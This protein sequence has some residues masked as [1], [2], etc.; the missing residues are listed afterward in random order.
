MKQGNG[1]AGLVF[2]EDPLVW[3]KNRREGAG[4]TLQV[5]IAEIRGLGLSHGMG[6]RGGCKLYPGGRASRV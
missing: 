4:E 2:W 5:S 3:R 6:S 1:M